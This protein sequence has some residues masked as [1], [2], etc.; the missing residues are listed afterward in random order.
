MNALPVIV[1]YFPDGSR[2]VKERRSDGPI[3]AQRALIDNQWKTI[4]EW[5]DPGLAANLLVN[6]GYESEHLPAINLLNIL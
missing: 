3:F 4:N 2:L 1:C 6:H 5:D